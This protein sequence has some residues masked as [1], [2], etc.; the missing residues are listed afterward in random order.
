MVEVELSAGEFPGRDEALALLGE[1]R[2]YPITPEVEGVAKIYQREM[3]M[4]RSS[5]AD[6][7]HL[8]AASVHE[9][10]YLLTWN[11]RHLAN[12]NKTERIQ[13]VNMRLGLF[14]PTILTPQMLAGEE[15]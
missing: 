1:M 12:T 3:L 11:C 7:M 6:A 8:A 4:P 10:D 14:T 9:L 5:G 2:L 15:S 13:V